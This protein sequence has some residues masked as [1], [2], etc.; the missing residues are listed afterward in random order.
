MKRVTERVGMRPLLSLLAKRGKM[1]T[2]AD[3]AAEIEADDAKPKK[4]KPHVV[5]KPILI[6]G[7]AARKVMVKCVSHNHP[8]AD[9]FKMMY[10]QNYEISYGD[11]VVNEVKHHVVIL[12][13][14][15]KGT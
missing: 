15:K 5:E 14:H 8:W 13:Q 10:W 11:A 3:L 2:D 7:D 9:G 1:Q 6:D 4:P 12:D